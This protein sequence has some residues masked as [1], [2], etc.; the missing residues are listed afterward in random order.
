MKKN[1]KSRM[2]WR[3]FIAISLQYIVL[4][5]AALLFAYIVYLKIT[6]Q[7]DYDEPEYR[8][9]EKTVVAVDASGKEHKHTLRT[10]V[11]DD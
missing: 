10:C 4:G 5:F 3:E 6:N 1:V 7:Y 11:Y 8:C 9:D 2:S